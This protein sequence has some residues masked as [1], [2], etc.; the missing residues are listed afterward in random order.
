MAGAALL[1]VFNLYPARDRLPGSGMG[2]CGARGARILLSAKLSAAAD[3]KCGQKYPG[4]F[5]GLG[6]LFRSA[7]RAI[8]ASAF[9]Q[10]GPFPCAT[11]LYLGF[12]ADEA[13][14]AWC[15]RA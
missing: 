6:I 7:P 1:C 2:L 11:F 15:R 10:S 12:N 8:G 9:S 3:T 4:C 13:R 5:A 14:P